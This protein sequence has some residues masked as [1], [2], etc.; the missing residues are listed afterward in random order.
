MGLRRKWHLLAFAVVG[1][2]SVLCGCGA[3]HDRGP[4]ATLVVKSAPVADATVTVDDVGYGAAPVTIEGLKPGSVL[5]VLEKDGFR[6]TAKNVTIPEAGGLV[7]EEITLNPLVGYA[8][9][10]TTP[11]GAEAFLDGATR[12]GKTP[13]VGISIPSG[14]HTIEFRYEN[15]AHLEEKLNVVPDYQ[16]SIV[17]L[18]K[19][20]PAELSVFSVPTAAQ[21]WINEELQDDRTPAK[22]A[23]APGE[24]T[25]SIYIDG[26]VSVEENFDLGANELRS[27][28]ARLLP[29]R[30]PRGMVFVPGGPFVMGA[31]DLAPDERPQR[32]VEVKPFY[33]DKYEV[34][35]G[36]FKRV[37]PNHVFEEGKGRFPA[38]GISFHRA[39]EYVSAV[40][41]RLPTEDEWEKAARGTDARQYP[42][43]NDFDKSVCNAEPRRVGAPQK[44]GLYRTGASPYGC[45]D[46]AGNVYEWTSS[47]Y[48]RY[49]G[50]A[51][52]V[53]DYGQVFRVLRGG[54][55]ASSPFEVR[56]V[57]RHYARMDD[58][59]EDVGLRCARD[60][61]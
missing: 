59:R 46:M 52:I 54:S 1:A 5:V 53:K 49:P 22:F 25:I 12:L 24:Y 10:R 34:T 20:L 57:R 14:E 43:G 48:Q 36:E 55:Y 11:A 13:L 30:V 42:W 15:Y 17:R 50:N 6:R 18:L 61:E 2:L 19:P 38:T 35:N 29:G 16:Y 31:N 58:R 33:I 3:F 28:E 37:F 27:V 32:S 56:C 45:L 23:L 44:V 51:D 60:S 40:K 8:A 9:L 7:E 26:Y 41:K 21:V 47:W 39:E 4:E